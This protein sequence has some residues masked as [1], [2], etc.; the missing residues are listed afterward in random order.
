VTLW[1]RYEKFMISWKLI[2][3]YIETLAFLFYI[4]FYYCNGILAHGSG[5]YFDGPGQWTRSTEGVHEGSMFCPLPLHATVATRYLVWRNWQ[6]SCKLKQNLL[7][8]STFN[9]I[10]ISNVIN[11]FLMASLVDVTLIWRLQQISKISKL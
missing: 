1:I 6:F 2:K 8:E 11:F 4:Y 9:H 7:L 3:Y 10:V 5:L